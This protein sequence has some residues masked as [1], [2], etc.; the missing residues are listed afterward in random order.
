MNHPL[1]NPVWAAL[2]SRHAAFA[3]KAGHA[4]RYP[5][6]MAPFVAVD[7]ADARAAE[8][9]A[10]LVAVG[11]AVLLV[12]MTLPLTSA[13]RVEPL[14]RIA[15]MT[16]RAR[17]AVNEGPPI[18]E[19]TTDAQVTDM[20]AL[21]ALVYPHYFRPRTVEMGRYVG[22]YDGERLV[23]MAGERMRFDGHQEISA[24]CTHPDYTGRGYAQRLL[25]S[26]S[27]DILERGDLPF[28]HVSHGNARAKALYERMGYAFR[29]DVALLEIRRAQ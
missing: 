8:Q 9:L 27:N 15:Q 24:I 20:L 19:L 14:V 22:I 23:A 16:C 26:L 12:G 28:L 18:S 5:A 21:T 1:D 25:A 29:T 2:T 11:E 13:W 7:A 6:D 17:L 4:V 10:G 3:S